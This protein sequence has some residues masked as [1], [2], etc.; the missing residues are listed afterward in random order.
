MPKLKKLYPT[1]I[2]IQVVQNAERQAAAEIELRRFLGLPKARGSVRRLIAIDDLSVGLT[3]VSGIDEPLVCPHLG[4]D[5]F[6]TDVVVIA[7]VEPE[8]RTVHLLGWTDPV[9]FYENHEPIDVEGA[10]SY[11]LSP[12]KFYPM[13]LLNELGAVTEIREEA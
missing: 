11:S 3:L 4:L 9:M 13:E 8:T 7:Y 5:E 12:D 2:A 1:G 10:E 6:I